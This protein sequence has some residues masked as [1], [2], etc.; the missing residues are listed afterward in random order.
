MKTIYFHIGLHKT[1][2]TALQTFFTKNRKKLAKYDILYPKSGHY[3]NGHHL[4]VWAQRKK[5]SDALIKGF[6]G[7]RKLNF[8]VHQLIEEID[9]MPCDNIL[10]SSENLAARPFI[11]LFR[12]ID[13]LKQYGFKGN[14]K[15]V[16]YLR[17]QHELLSSYYSQYVK[18]STYSGR[19]SEFDGYNNKLNYEILL[20][21]LKERF[22]KKNI[23]V[24]VYEKKQFI[25]GN[26]FDD[27]LNSV[28]NI[29][30]SNEFILPKKDPNPRLNVKALEYKRLT[31]EYFH[32]KYIDSF[33][34]TTLLKYS[35]LVDPS[36]HKAFQKYGLLSEEQKNNIFKKY[37]KS[38]QNVAKDFFGRQKLFISEIE[39]NYDHKIMK[40]LN[41]IDVIEISRF[42]LESK[43]KI[44]I[45]NEMLAEI[46]IKSTMELILEKNITFN[47]DKFEQIIIP[48]DKSIIKT[49]ISNIIKKIKLITN[50]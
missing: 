35:R 32:N 43:F 47:E 17:R 4:L 49:I 19:I 39:K 11:E 45:T 7:N 20:N 50:F 41:I 1:G 16:I 31:N 42:L 23:I 2:T 33:F 36:T 14:I 38:N 28:F 44:E 37:Y 12:V 8:F 5:L 21:K 30:L 15:I 29:N 26:I 10:I 24:R 13:A 9:N 18:Q 25:N 46:I 3:I 40:N 6:I 27:F 22:E 34:E 48:N